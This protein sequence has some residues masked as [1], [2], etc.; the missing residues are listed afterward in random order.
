MNGLNTFFAAAW[1]HFT[2]LQFWISVAVT[3][4]VWYVLSLAFAHLLAGAGNREPVAAAR[5]AMPL[6]LIVMVIGLAVSEYFLLNPGNVPYL[7]AVT[8]ASLLITAV[9]LVIFN[10]LGR[11][12]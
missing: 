9:L 2:Q 12:N 3:L 5:T 1:P 6:G 10:R 11:D 7:A 4:L 8:V